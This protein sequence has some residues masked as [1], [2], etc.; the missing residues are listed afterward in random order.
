[1]LTCRK[2]Q[3]SFFFLLALSVTTIILSLS[4]VSVSIWWV[5]QEKKKRQKNRAVVLLFTGRLLWKAS[6]CLTDQVWSGGEDRFFFIFFFCKVSNFSNLKT[7]TLLVYAELLWCF[8][9]LP[10]S[11]MDYRIFNMWISLHE[12]TQR[13]PLHKIWLQRN[14]RVSTKP[15]T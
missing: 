4:L 12:Y 7:M 10:N 6:I 11:D 9:N 14:L 5:A 2:T 8:H 3:H 15:S 1:M 13:G